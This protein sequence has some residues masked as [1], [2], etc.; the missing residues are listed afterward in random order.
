MN[1]AT[2][3][4][5]FRPRPA[6]KSELLEGAAKLKHRLSRH[7]DALER[8][9][10]G[11]VEDVAAVLRTALC[12][13]DGDNAVLRLCRA[14]GVEN[15]RLQVSLPAPS[16]SDVLLAIGGEPLV[17]DPDGTEQGRIV[18][19]ETWIE[20][21]ALVV[22]GG[23]PRRVSTWAQV[24]TMYANTFG[25]HLSRTVPQLV[26]ASKGSTFASRS[27]QEHVIYSA[28]LVGERALDQALCAV[29]GQPVAAT[30]RG[31]LTRVFG[32]I[33]RS[34]G[35]SPVFEFGLSAPVGEPHTQEEVLRVH[36]DGHYMRGVV[37]WQTDTIYDLDLSVSHP[38]LPTPEWWLSD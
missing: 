1:G 20:E 35:K 24:I 9:Q 23:I 28:G 2:S 26:F 18:A 17:N 25:A 12:P 14:H 11:A 19:L 37:R 29:T 33:I 3:D 16:D 34:N 7:L 21:P 13:G 4:G 6:T 5:P 38:P 8:G 31:T 22:A 36:F 15:P 10:V 27:M 30:S 32:L